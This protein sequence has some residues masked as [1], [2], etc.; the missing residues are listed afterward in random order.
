[1]ATGRVEFHA[2][3]HAVLYGTGA[4]VPNHPPQD[5]ASLVQGWLRPE[6]ARRHA[7]LLRATMR[8]EGDL[9][10]E[11]L[12]RDPD[13]GHEAWIEA[14]ATLVRDGTGRPS[15]VVGVMRNTTEQRRAEE[16]RAAERERL[17]VA[18][19]V[20]AERQA[21]LRRIVRAQEEE[22][23]RVARDVHD[24][25]TQLAHAAALRLDGLVDDLDGR[26][27]P[28]ERSDLARARDLARRAAAD[29]RRLIAGLRPDTLDELGLVGALRQEVEALVADGW[30]AEL[31][32]ADPAGVRFDPEAEITLYRIAQEA[33]ANVRR[34]AGTT[35]VRLTLTRRNGDV[36]L[37]VRDWGRG[38]GRH[39]ALAGQ[40]GEHVGLTGMRE[41]TALVGGRFE[42]R[43][44]PSGGTTVRA[45]VPV[46]HAP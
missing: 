30:D 10:N 43:S 2:I 24:G 37:E 5:W 28:E 21:L 16:E 42:V 3:V 12:V 31:V 33:L 46:R 45:W 23:A 38:F 34:H 35:R 36:R 4:D 1:V 11:M 32:D 8:G 17:A 14:M 29:A 40:A 19:A 27:S 13:T 15:R 25:V 7:E 18:E 44:T 41:R 26:L 39:A 6:D 9:R 20:A 22:R